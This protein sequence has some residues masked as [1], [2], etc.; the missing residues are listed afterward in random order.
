MPEDE[1]QLRDLLSLLAKLEQR[2]LPCVRLHELGDP[3]KYTTV[4]LRHPSF[5]TALKVVCR[6]AR[7][8]A[9]SR[10]GGSVVA[11]DALVV[12]LL[13]CSRGG[14]G[15][16]RLRLSLGL[17]LKLAVLGYMVI[18]VLVVSPGPLA[19]VLLLVREDVLHLSLLFHKAVAVVEGGKVQTV[20]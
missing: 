11:R 7:N 3:L 19:R 10:H 17:C 13:S 16:L 9:A 15:G 20:Q 8:E 6:S 1:R 2:R 4:F 5:T 12:L 18:R 14:C